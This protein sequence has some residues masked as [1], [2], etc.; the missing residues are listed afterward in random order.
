MAD[1]ISEKKGQ[2]AMKILSFDAVFCFTR[3]IYN[4]NLE[5]V[6]KRNLS[7]H[8]YFSFQRFSFEAVFTVLL[9]WT[10]YSS[11]ILVIMICSSVMTI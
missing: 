8:S 7:F 4:G 6:T 5:L 9:Q 2:I 10:I 11:N 3:L 1:N